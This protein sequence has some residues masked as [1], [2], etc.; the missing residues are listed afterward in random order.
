MSDELVEQKDEQSLIKPTGTPI[1]R[2]LQ[3]ANMAEQRIEAIKK[4]KTVALALTNANDW[5]DQQGK[6]YLQASGSEKIA[7]AFDI[8]WEFLTIAPD[9]EEDTEGHYTYTYHGRFSM[10]GRH[11][12]IDGSRSSN[13]GFFK[14]YN[15]PEGQKRKEKPIHERTNKRDVKMAALTNLL[16][17][18]ITRLLGIRNLTYTDLE[19]F[20]GITK[21]MLG[22]VEYKSDKPPIKQPEARKPEPAPQPEEKKLTAKESLI[23][24]LKEYTGNDE[25]KFKK[26]LKEFTAF[27]DNK[28]TMDITKV[29]DKWAASALGKLR[30]KVK[31][32]QVENCT[33]DPNSCDDSEFD[34][35]FAY[36]KT[37]DGKK[38]PH[39]TGMPF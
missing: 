35:K 1:D 12:Q 29:S 28:G 13:D 7:G 4:I 15:Y 6:P 22:K 33:Q 19:K 16:G 9:Y 38:C 26:F 34:E 8:S 21:D 5:V 17:N 39:Q 2:L 23:A 10:A 3:M 32:E 14:Q 27:G 24:E 30:D 25:E 11:I 20:A 36:C 37:K 31:E 18:G